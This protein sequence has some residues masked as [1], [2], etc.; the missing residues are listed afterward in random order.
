MAQARG[1]LVVEASR[2][3]ETM[4]EG[5]IRAPDSTARACHEVEL[6]LL[7]P[8]DMLEQLREAPIIVQCARNK[9]TVRRLEAVYYDTPDHLFASHGL[10]LRVRRSG[11][12]HTQTLKRA[13]AGNVLTRK[14]WETPVDSFVPN[15]AHLPIAEL[16]APFE[17]LAVEGLTPIFTTKVRRHVRMLDLPDATVEIAFDNGEIEAGG[18]SQ[19]LSEIELELKGGMAGALYDFGLSL[20]D[21][22]P[23]Q[24]GTAGKAE[25]GYALAL[26]RH[27]AATRAMPLALRAENNIDGAIMTLLAGCQHHLIGNVA[28]A[29]GRDTEGVHQMRVALRR[30]R[31]AVTLLCKELP[32]PSLLALSAEARQLSR[33]LGPA[34]NWDV[35]VGETLAEIERAGLSGIDIAGLRE[36]AQP[37]RLACH[38]A[39]RD[40][41]ADPR[42]GRFL[43]SLGRLIE[44][45]SWRSEVESE[46]LSVI[47]EP[48]GALADRALTRL[49][50]Q[51]LRRGR[52]F[53]RLPPEKRHDL[54]LTLKKL[55]YAVEFFLPLYAGRPQVRTYLKTLSKLQDALGA[56]NDASSSAPL[57][58][59]IAQGSTSPDVHR[60]L[61]AVIGWQGRGEKEPQGALRKTWRRF[62]QASPFW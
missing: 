2:D 51:A 20:L 13:V 34:R 62:K 19:P 30:L 5:A 32:V 17:G 44:R 46:R 41:L 36:A 43:L 61:G 50:S 11:K 56:A 49:R 39:V 12:Q 28:T 24:L 57:L 37:Y 45:R 26:D 1:K 9:G 55:R 52:G 6:R 16:G 15:L 53:G 21:A 33:L 22:A 18:R 54:R 8:P 47:T 40:G 48:V 27:P 59:E 60:A 14:E 7:A 35:F 10:S 31:T 38:G 42:T 25:R 58:H 3:N 29:F 4:L 23:L